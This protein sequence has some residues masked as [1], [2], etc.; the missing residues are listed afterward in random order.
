MPSAYTPN[1]TVFPATI[2]RPA[3]GEARTAG[4]VNTPLEQIADRTERIYR[5]AFAIAPACWFLG[6]GSLGNAGRGCAYG[7]DAAGGIPIYIAVGDADAIKRSQYLTDWNNDGAPAGSLNL[8]NIATNGTGNWVATAS[9][10]VT[11]Y[12]RAGGTWSQTVALP[13]S[14]QLI[15]DVCWHAGGGGLFIAVGSDSGGGG[16]VATSLLG[17]D[18]WTARTDGSTDTLKLVAS[19]GTLA[20]AVR[21]GASDKIY[22][23]PDG[24]TWTERTLPSSGTAVGLV[25]S[26]TRAKWMLTFTNGH[27]LTSTDGITWT[28]AAIFGATSYATN[29]AAA[30]A[31]FMGVGTRPGGAPRIVYTLDDGATWYQHFPFALADGN[32]QAELFVAE[33][34][35]VYTKPGYAHSTIPFA[36]GLAAAAAF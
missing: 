8:D 22:T 31:M 29:L 5:N 3:D 24:I 10:S 7:L 26:A 12:R 11:V 2:S 17:A 13:D 19:S 16:Y 18:P 36:P 9:N 15:A 35:L 30:G 27:V 25:Y 33:G 32:G 6:S 34:R 1:P 20:I 4:S 21:N 28:D 14:P 23:S